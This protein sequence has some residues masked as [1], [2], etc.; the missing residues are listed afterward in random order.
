MTNDHD[1]TIRHA[2]RQNMRP[3]AY[4]P[5]AILHLMW[6]CAD[7]SLKDTVVRSL[8]FAAFVDQGRVNKLAH[9]HNTSQWPESVARKKFPGICS[10]LR[11][12]KTGFR[13]I[14]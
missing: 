4:R 2:W 9:A 14:Y 11:R 3:V 6:F 10:H 8:G 5:V 7:P 12:I 1:E 13:R